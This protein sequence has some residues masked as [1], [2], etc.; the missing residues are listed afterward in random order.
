[1]VVNEHTTSKY[2]ASSPNATAAASRCYIV[3]PSVLCSSLGF[4]GIPSTYDGC[5]SV[6][7]YICIACSP[8]QQQQINRQCRLR[9]MS[10]KKF[11]L[12]LE[13]YGLLFGL[14]STVC[15]RYSGLVCSVLFSGLLVSLG[16]HADDVWLVCR[17]VA[18]W[19]SVFI[20][21]PTDRP[22]RIYVF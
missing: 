15:V 9:S 16:G 21:C 20:T 3:F 18:R 14:C 17:W 10:L 13:Y 7:W 5:L 1:M 22:N 2:T 11:S 12:C 4:C 8:Q 6:C 19:S